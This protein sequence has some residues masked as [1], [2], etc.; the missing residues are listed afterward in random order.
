M[1]Y[2]GEDILNMLDVKHLPP[3]QPCSSRRR[4]CMG[5]KGVNKGGGR[6][7]EGDRGHK[8]GKG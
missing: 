8:E 7:R 3:L 6:G 2:K 5:K 4:I 1:K